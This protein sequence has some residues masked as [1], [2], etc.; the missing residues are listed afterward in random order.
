MFDNNLI[1]IGNL[2]A[3][4]ELR[5]TA[6]GLP[7][8]N[9]TVA[10]TERKYENGQFVDGNTLFMRCTVWRDLAEHVASS[11]SKGQRVMVT[12]RLKQEEYTDKEGNKRVSV[13]LDV[14]ELGVSLKFGTATF[15]RAQQNQNQNQ[16]QN[17][18]PAQQQQYQ[19]PAQQQ[20][21]PPVQQQQYQQPAQQQYQQ[22][23]QQVPDT[24]A[25]AGLSF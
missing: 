24:S 22:P 3:D 7:V 19:Q 17:Q 25:A 13:S 12:G 18:P 11:L 2:T 20:Y 9:F 16:N 14:D 5:H 21:Q 8:T 1:L 10:G 23:V 6:N 4:P 15:Q